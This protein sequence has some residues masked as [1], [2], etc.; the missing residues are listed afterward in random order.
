MTDQRLCAP[1]PLHPPG[2]SR[3]ATGL[4]CLSM[5]APLRG[6]ASTPSQG[7]RILQ[8]LPALRLNNPARLL[9]LVCSARLRIGQDGAPMDFDFPL[10]LLSG[11]PHSLSAVADAAAAADLEVDNGA[12]VGVG[13]RVR[14]ED[15]WGHPAAAGEDGAAEVE[16]EERLIAPSIPSSPATRPAPPRVR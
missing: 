13:V 8:P 14:V 15:R 5:G 4:F 1:V 9:Q 10:L 7:F 3:S 2:A 16:V 11:T 12:E 6:R